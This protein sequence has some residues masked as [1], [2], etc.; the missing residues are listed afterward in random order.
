MNGAHFHLLVNHIPI[1]GTIFGLLILLAVIILKNA[2]VKLTGLAT[3]IAATIIVI[4]ALGRAFPLLSVQWPRA[5]I[6]HAHQLVNQ[7]M[8]ISVQRIESKYRLKCI[9]SSTSR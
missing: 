5:K 8:D 9:A 6:D 4:F 7:V 1:V 3:L 2:T